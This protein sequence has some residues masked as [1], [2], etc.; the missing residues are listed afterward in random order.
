LLNNE[1]IDEILNASELSKFSENN[2]NIITFNYDRSLEESLF[3]SLF[4]SF[5]E[6]GAQNAEL[7]KEINIYHVYGKICDLQWENPMH[8]EKYSTNNILDLAYD[9]R[10][11]IQI[12]YDERKGENEKI[13]EM[14]K[15]AKKIFFLG[16]GYSQENLEALGLQ[17]LLNSNQYIY[18]S[19]YK[20]TEAERT[21]IKRLL[22]YLNPALQANHIKIKDLDC[23]G[24]WREYF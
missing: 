21:K 19:A 8:G 24:M 6:G 14:I 13:A 10:N 7:V 17:S 4:F 12:I 16:F 22:H 18:G 20:S 2:L 3:R 23:V 9:L 1:M 5:P 11:N 15:K